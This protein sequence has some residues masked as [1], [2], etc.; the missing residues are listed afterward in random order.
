MELKRVNVRCA[1]ALEVLVRKKGL[2]V[3]KDFVTID[4]DSYCFIGN[5]AGD[6]IYGK[7]HDFDDIGFYEVTYIYNNPELIRTDDGY[8]IG[9]VETWKF[10]VEFLFTRDTYLTDFNK[11]FTFGDFEIE[12]KGL[13]M[14]KDEIEYYLEMNE[15]LIC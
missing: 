10:E 4:M 11:K 9:N 2:F 1:S 12:F 14:N 5:M 7:Y 15:A 3:N 8:V 6:I 13:S